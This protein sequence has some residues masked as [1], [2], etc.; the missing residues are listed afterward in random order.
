MTTSLTGARSSSPA[1]RAPRRG[2]RPRAARP[3]RAASSSSDTTRRSST[4]SRRAARRPRRRPATSPTKPPSAPRRAAARRLG[5]VDGILHLVGGWRGGGGLAGRPRR[6]TG[7]SRRSFT[8]LRHVTRAFD[9]DLR[10]SAAGRLAIVSSTAVARPLAGGANYA[11][12]KAASE[13]WARAVAQGFAKAAR[14]AGG[15]WARHPSSSGSRRWTGSRSRSPTRFLALVRTRAVRRPLDRQR[16]VACWRADA[17][18]VGWMTVTTLHD[19]NVRGFASDN[20]SGIH[21][22]VLAAIA[23]ANDGHQVAYGEDEYTARLQEVFVA[24]LRRG[25]RGVPGLQR[26]RRERRRAAVDAPPLGRRDRGIH[27]AHQRRRGR[28]ARARRRDQD[29]ATSRPTTASSPPSSS[30]ARRGAGATSTARSR[31][32]VSI[33][34][35]TELGTLYTRR[36]DPR[37]SPTTSTATACACTWTARASPTPPPR[38]ACRC[39]RSPATWASTC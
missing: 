37:R 29:P 16:S 17:A 3:R 25:R 39:A 31:S 26:H 33:T 11:A 13:A 22:E 24:A 4:R 15:R 8:A 1:E 7:S 28:R 5:R 20:Y 2:R 9:A 19:P 6:T 32:S 12:V 27:R 36:R 34:Q 10:A 30:T 38:S 18:A 35:S 23:A 21:P 14:D